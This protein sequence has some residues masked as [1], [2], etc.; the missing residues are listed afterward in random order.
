MVDLHNLFVHVGVPYI[1]ALREIRGN[2][3]PSIDVGTYCGA[4]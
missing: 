4:R 2:A 3:G 1:H